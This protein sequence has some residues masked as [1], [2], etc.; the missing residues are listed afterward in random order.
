M[1]DSPGPSPLSI[2]W[3]APAI[4]SVVLFGEGL[5]LV[6]TLNPGT[7]GDRWVYFGLASMIVQ[8][9]VLLTLGSL[10]LA[11]AP[12]ARRP[13]QQTAWIAV[14][15]LM[16]STWLVGTT[17]WFVLRGFFGMNK[18]AWLDLLWQ[19]TAIALIVSLLG[20]ATIQNYW[21]SRLLAVRAKQAQLEALQARIHPHFLFNTLNTGA[22]LVR[23]QPAKAEQLLLDLSDLFRA[24]LSGP[25][26][27]PLSEELALTKRYLEIE[28]LRLGPRL[29]LHWQVPDDLPDVE[30]PILTLQPLAENAVRHGVEP[31]TSGGDID[32]EVQVGAE[33]DPVR[34]T[35]ANTIPAGPVH[36]AGH[37]VGLAS[38]RERILAM[39][40]G[41]AS[42]E[43]GVEGNRHVV[44]IQLQKQPA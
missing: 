41:N 21:Q 5:A 11:R 22:A 43:V 4:M 35:I 23:A 9:I 20:L 31:S 27:V 26:V 8:W 24:S 33:T 32:I 28:T 17:S 12:L 37:H 14:L 18:G 36:V 13:W 15:L 16:A 29:R 39:A 38:A 6:L 2:L 25:R 7:A 40:G 3:Q 1:R 30:I 34:I 44:A 19:L 10:Y 42:V